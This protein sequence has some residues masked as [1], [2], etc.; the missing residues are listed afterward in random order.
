MGLS[1]TFNELQNNWRQNQASSKL[2]LDSDLLIREV[3]RNKEAFE[4]TIFWR[5]FREVAISLIMAAAFLAGAFKARENIWAAGAFAILAFVC[6]FV[7]AFFIIDRRLQ[8]KKSPGHSDSL[9][10][11]LE[12]SLNQINHQIWLLKNVFWWYLLPLGA[13]VIV[14]CS[15]VS[16]NV[17]RILHS[18]LVLLTFGFALL[19]TALMFWGVYR[20]NQYAVNKGLVPRRQE[21][22]LLLKTLAADNIIS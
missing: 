2:T 20:L 1:M 19:L 13:G 10:A 3:K 5:D 4:A 6:L 8:R 16:W 17:F 7:A 14:F 9:L 12:S 18:A 11:C 22:E 15:I 21:L